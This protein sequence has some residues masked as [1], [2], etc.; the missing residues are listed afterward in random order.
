MEPEKHVLCLVGNAH[1]DPVWQWRV[2][3]GLALIRS[4]FSAALDRMEEF[5]D[6]VF[7]SACAAY[8]LW[9]KE[10]EPE[11]FARIQQR[12]REGRWQVVGGMWVQPDCNLPCGEAFARHLLYSQRFFAECFGAPA[13]TGYNVDSFGHNGMLPQLFRKAGIENYVYMRPNDQTEKPELGVQNLH[14][15]QSP[16]GSRVLAYRIP[17]RFGGYAGEVSADRIAG[18]DSL[19]QPQMLFYGVGNHGGGPGIRHLRD[20][21][22][23][24]FAPGGERFRF[25]GPDDYFALVRQSGEA[26]RAP[27]H[28]GDLQHH[29]SGCY[30]ANSAV[31]KQNRRAE[32]ALIAAEKAAALSARLTGGASCRTA[33]ADAWQRLM[34]SQFHDILAGCSIRP[35]YDDARAAFGYAREKALEVEN[36]ALQRISWRIG[37]TRFFENRPSEMRARLW[38]HDGEGSPMVVFN[39]HSFAVKTQAAFGMG[40]V[41]GVT[42]SS[43]RDVP[44][45]LVRAPY[46]DGGHTRECLFEAELPALGWAVYYIWKDEQNHVPQ[47]VENEFRT[48]PDTLENSVVRLRFDPATGALSSYYDKTTG[49]ELAGGLLARAVMCGDEK[50]DTWAHGEFNFNR[51]LETFAGAGAEVVETGP[52]RAGLRTVSRCGGTTLTQTFFLE[53][54]SRRVDVQVRLDFAEHYKLV[55]LCFAAAAAGQ[56][57][58]VYSMPF[59][60]LEKP[61]DG[62]EEPAQTWAAV[63]GTDGL[64][65]AVLNDCKYSWCARG[66]ELRVIAAR[67]CAYLDHFGQSMRDGE[68]RFEDQG[69]QEFR[70]ALLPYEGDPAPIAREAAL[71][72]LPCRLVSETHHTGSLPPVYAGIRVSD[73]RVLVESIKYAED[74]GGLVLRA[75]ECAGRPVHVRIELPAAGAWEGDFAPEE[76]KTLLLPFDG[77]PARELLL[78]EL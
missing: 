26:G 32:Q 73:D 37:T 78:T 35:A 43:D 77:S 57:T 74:D 15:W 71:L 24:R 46:T 50:N 39:P 29:A 34:F 21:S 75:V 19:P 4:T 45:Q 49:R 3:E 22:A 67:G 30:S 13:R 51:D 56:P 47:P 44:F 72:N 60:F 23:L 18:L 31:K 64:G 7:T 1:L 40:M 11:L 48:G 69:E 58:A 76:F 17:D 6:Y 10:S 20:A 25:A 12:V 8:Y 38:V 14:W 28:T 65:L 2:P 54:G 61:A 42:D 63:R 33:V 53:R 9:I 70:L 52:V 55:K 36:Y 5:P 16:D 62:R 68:M 41:S 66:A 59:G 27:L